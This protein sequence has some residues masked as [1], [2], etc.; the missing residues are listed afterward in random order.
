MLSQA[1]AP[2]LAEVTADPSAAVTPSWVPDPDRQKLGT[3]TIE[4]VL[5]APDDAPR[6]ELRDGVMITVPTPTAGHQQ[7]M[8]WLW[9]ALRSAAP[10][11]Y[12]VLM[13]VGLMIDGSNTFEPDVLV[14]NGP[15]EPSLHFFPATQCVLAV[16]IVSP[17]TKR[18][19]R[20]EKP[21]QYAAARVPHY[22]RVEQNPTTI[23][24]TELFDDHYELILQAAAP[25]D[26]LRLNE[27]F[28]LRI[29]LDSL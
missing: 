24:T 1:T 6:M 21:A 16:E 19:D 5:G 9:Q 8:G 15:V 14:L 29:D 27:P 28:P 10:P 2:T 23:Y 17:S 26:V 22:W 25:D 3:F 11:G 20:I 18:R 12:T 4:D 13:A 7:I